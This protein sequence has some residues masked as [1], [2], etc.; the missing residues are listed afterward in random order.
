MKSDAKLQ[1]CRFAA[2]DF[3]S[4]GGSRD[5]GLSRAHLLSALICCWS[6]R[7]VYVV[8]SDLFL[9]IGRDRRSAKHDMVATR[10]G[11]FS[12]R[13][14]AVE[15]SLRAILSS[16][17]E[18]ASNCSCAVVMQLG[19]LKSEDIWGKKQLFFFWFSG[20]PGCSSGL[21]RREKKWGKAYLQEGRRKKP[22]ILYLL[23][24]SFGRTDFSR[25]F[26]FELLD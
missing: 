13:L 14:G 11:Q 25:I 16:M 23:V 18:I 6:L 5:E 17:Q 22:L 9:E 10:N 3:F 24:P 4:N 26:M 12:P 20:F 7:F 19:F 8:R 1:C 21:Q 2:V 15:I